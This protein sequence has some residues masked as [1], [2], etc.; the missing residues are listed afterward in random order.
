MGVGARPRV[1]LSLLLHARTVYL[2]ARDSRRK[3]GERDEKGAV[4]LDW[5]SGEGDEEELERVGLS[6]LTA[7]SRLRRAVP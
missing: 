7:A 4:T 2:K 3:D 6:L 5:T 1:A